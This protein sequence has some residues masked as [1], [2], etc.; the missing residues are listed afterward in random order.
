MAVPF[1]HQRRAVDS[2]GERPGGQFA[3]VTAE[4]HGAAELVHAKQIAQL[5]DDLVGA[6]SSTSVESAPSSP[7]T[8]RANSTVAHWKP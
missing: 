4:A 2:P 3:G 7:Q 5:V 8:W 1:V 6:D